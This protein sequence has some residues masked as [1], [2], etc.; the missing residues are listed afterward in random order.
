MKAFKFLIC[1]ISI[2]ILSSCHHESEPMNIALKFTQLN[3]VVASHRND[4]DLLPWK[5]LNHFM[6]INSV[7]DV[8]ATQ[9]E[10]FIEENPNWLKIDFSS[11]TIIAFRSI[12][13][14]FDSW[15]YSTVIGFS[16]INYEDSPIN[17][18]KGDYRLAINDYYSKEDDSKDEEDRIY[19]VAIVTHKINS[20]AKI[21]VV[22]GV[23]I[24]DSSIWEK[25]K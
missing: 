12:L 7:E 20:D 25:S 1:A 22:L 6:I 17:Y 9:T 21:H 4:N 19:Q 13:S 24:K 14:S 10:R 16:R 18:H 11:E 8:Y 3:T 23:G 5:G 2:F 15:Q